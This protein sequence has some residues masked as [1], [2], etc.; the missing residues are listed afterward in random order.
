MGVFPK[1]SGLE[2]DDGGKLESTKFCCNLAVRMTERQELVA[3]LK[4]FLPN[5]KPVTH[6]SFRTEC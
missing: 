5:P 6:A 1:N 2:C 3:G 4:A